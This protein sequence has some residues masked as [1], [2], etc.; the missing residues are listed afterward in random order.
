MESGD[1]DENGVFGE[2]LEILY[3]GCESLPEFSDD[4]AEA[5]IFFEEHRKSFMSGNQI[6]LVS[7]HD[8]HD[9]RGEI[10]VDIKN[11]VQRLLDQGLTRSM[12]VE[13][14]H[15]PGTGCSNIARQVLSSSLRPWTKALN[16][17]K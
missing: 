8:N 7:L 1:L 3:Q 2:H 6:S 4:P 10:S 9:A 5:E 17:G 16:R 13:F 15:S 11:H 12:I 14:R